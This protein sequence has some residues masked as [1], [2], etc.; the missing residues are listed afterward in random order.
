MPGRE[1]VPNI[2]GGNSEQVEARC[3]AVIL[4]Q[5]IA[6]A[7]C[8]GYVYATFLYN[9]IHT[10]NWLSLLCLCRKAREYNDGMQRTP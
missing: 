6:I 7:I 9:R 8:R 10:P 4:L 3:L 5:N 1:T 2:T